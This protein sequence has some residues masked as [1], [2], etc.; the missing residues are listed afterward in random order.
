MGGEGESASGIT[1]W[2]LPKRTAMRPARIEV[3]GDRVWSDGEKVFQHEHRQPK[4]RPDV[5]RN[6]GRMMC[7]NLW[8]SF[9]VFSIREVLCRCVFCPFI[10]SVRPPVPACGP[11]FLSSPP[12]V[13]H[14]SS[15]GS[16]THAF[17]QQPPSPPR[18]ASPVRAFT[19]HFP[20]STSPSGGMSSPGGGCSPE[21]LSTHRASPSRSR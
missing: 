16:A 2:L 3:E 12:V 8:C 17:Q 14:H 1:C 21:P 19:W 18:P 13:A 20:P 10:R 11:S 7:V 9:A 6:T 5:R 4:E 15:V